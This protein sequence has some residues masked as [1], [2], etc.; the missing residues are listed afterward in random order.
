MLRRKILQTLFT[1]PALQTLSAQEFSRKYDCDVIVVGGGGAGL[2]AAVRAS[3]LGAKV[4]L[5]EKY[6]FLGGNTL[7]SGGF[8][9]VVDPKRQEPLGIDDC[10]DRH[11][12]D[13][14]ENGDK[15]ANPGLIKKLV[16][17][18][19]MMLAW[20]EEKGVKFQDEVIEIYGSHFPRCHKPIY[21]N[22][23]AYVRALTSSLMAL[24]TEVLTNTSAFKLIQEK[25][26]VVGV[27]VCTGIK[28]FL[29]RASKGVILTSGGFGANPNL[30]AKYDARLGRLPTNCS[31]GSK[32]EML[33]AAQA[34]GI[35]C[36]DL[37]E[38]QCL[39]GP[40]DKNTLRVRF[41]NDIRR[42]IFVNQQGQRFVDERA[43]RDVLKEKILSQA[44]QSCFC[45]ID[46]EALKTYDLLVRRDAVR[47][48]E[49]GAAFKAESLEELA[50][51]LSVPSE[52]LKHS[53]KE[54]NDS[55]RFDEPHSR[56]FPIVQPPFW[57]AHVG[58]RIHYTMG[59]VKINDLANCLKKGEPVKGLYAAGEVTGG[60]H[61]RNRIG[62]NGL[63]DAFTFGLIAA[64]SVLSS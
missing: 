47:A 46:N 9:G 55:I 11:F 4:I 56:R 25:E 22:G 35:D 51:L 8:L 24:K 19:P 32:G 30:V 16:H 2:A 13:I 12:K 63:T 45:I 29:I 40:L 18:A 7:I 48:A 52:V 20:L 60:I 14:W 31:S 23:T 26:R 54:R 37:N 5:V 58:M 44:S 38:I 61:G 62:G 3:E 15:L 34:I 43:R 41:H 33:L 39:P 64:E 57:A 27:R 50:T 21:P 59:G 10:A 1:L 17:E 6:P 53:I 36:V 28:E 42:F 49:S